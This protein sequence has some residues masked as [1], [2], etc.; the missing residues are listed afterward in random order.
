M[1]TPYATHPAAV[2]Y[3][4]RDKP[5]AV[6]AVMDWITQTLSIFGAFT[7][8]AMSLYGLARWKKVRKPADY[9]SEIRRVEQIANGGGDG[10]AATDRSGDLAE[11]LDERLLK[12]RQELIEDI[13]EGRIKGDQS[14]ANILVLLKD[15]RRNLPRPDGEPAPMSVLRFQRAS[16]N[17]A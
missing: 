4:D 12:L 13:C 14:I 7:A 3:L 6:K 17:A 1:A 15:V 11:E 16:K 2:A 8:G 10:S 5:L 9:F